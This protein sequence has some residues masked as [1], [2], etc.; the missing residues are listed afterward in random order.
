MQKIRLI[1]QLKIVLF[2][3][4]SIQKNKRMSLLK[5]ST[6]FSSCEINNWGW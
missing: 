2:E 1:I 6:F 3:E 5:Q 4:K